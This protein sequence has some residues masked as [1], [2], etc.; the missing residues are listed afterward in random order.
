MIGDI[1]YERF[2]DEKGRRD[3]LIFGRCRKSFLEHV[4]LWNAI[5]PCLICYNTALTEASVKTLDLNV[6]EM[7]C[8]HESHAASEI[9]YILI[10][11]INIELCGNRDNNRL[12]M[13]IRACH[14]LPR[15]MIKGGMYA[16]EYQCIK[17]AMHDMDDDILTIIR[18]IIDEI[19]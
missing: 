15:C 13:L 2:V 12:N 17:Y 9:L 16:P 3:Y 1:L 8:L 11:Q 6:D 4:R 18:P 10:N 14:N 7:K 19:S 5:S